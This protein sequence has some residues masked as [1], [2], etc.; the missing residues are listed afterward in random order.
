MNT[1]LLYEV[2]VNLKEEMSQNMRFSVLIILVSREGSDDPVHACSIARAFAAHIHKA[3]VKDQ[4][5]KI[6]NFRNSNFKTC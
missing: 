5:L 1:F 4:N 6:L 2:T 3:W